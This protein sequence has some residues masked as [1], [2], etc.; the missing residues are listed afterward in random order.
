MSPARL[1]RRAPM[2]PA[3]GLPERLIV[4]TCS[5]S[6]ADCGVG[7]E[8]VHATTPLSTGYST[9]ICW[10]DIRTSASQSHVIGLGTT[11]ARAPMII[12]LLTV[13]LLPSSCPL[14]VVAELNW[15]DEACSTCQSHTHRS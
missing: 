12:S 10:T 3:C 13:S 7:V 6:T 11:H 14:R 15:Q 1:E 2:P 8:V 9:R 4:A 5:R